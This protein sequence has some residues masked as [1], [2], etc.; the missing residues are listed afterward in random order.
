MGRVSQQGQV[1]SLAS[2]CGPVIGGSQVVLHI[3]TPSEASLVPRLDP[4]ELA[5]NLLHGLAHDIG[6][7]IEPT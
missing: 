1:H 5:E 2:D 3:P 7:H 6:Q 4:S